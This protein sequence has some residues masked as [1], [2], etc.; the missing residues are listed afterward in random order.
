MYIIK[1]SCR[2]TDLNLDTCTTAVLPRY[3]SSFYQ[4]K[5]PTH[6][7]RAARAHTKYSFYRFYT[8]PY[9]APHSTPADLGI[10]MHLCFL[11]PGARSH[12]SACFYRTRKT[13]RVRDM[14][15]VFCAG[16]RI[17]R[18]NKYLHSC[19]KFSCAVLGSSKTA[20]F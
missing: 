20:F 5:H 19:T 7:A 18:C 11:A 6:R 10:S 3:Y 1:I 16:P 14:C 12:A 8:A 9:G 15:N 17:Q 13:Q 4:L 2:S